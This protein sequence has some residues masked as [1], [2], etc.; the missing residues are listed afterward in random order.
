MQARAVLRVALS[1]DD[2]NEIWREW[3][4]WLRFSM[5]ALNKRYVTAGWEQYAET[6]PPALRA[7]AKVEPVEQAEVA[8]LTFELGA[9]HGYDLYFPDP[10]P[11]EQ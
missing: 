1:L 2:P 4:S 3:S 11:K 8:A 6:L 7:M 5:M 9:A 10:P